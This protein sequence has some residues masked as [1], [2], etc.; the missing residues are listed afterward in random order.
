MSDLR[1]VH[2]VIG[3]VIALVT[4][5]I[6]CASNLAAAPIELLN[7]GDFEAVEGG[8]PKGWSENNAGVLSSVSDSHSG[9]LAAKWEW[10]PH[11]WGYAACQSDL[12]P[13]NPKATYRLSI[14][15]KGTGS[16]D[17]AVYQFNAALFVGTAFPKGELALTPQW[18]KL[19]V[20]YK[21]TDN[22]NI[23]FGKFAIHL[24]GENAVAILDDAS[25]RFDP[26]ENP[27]VTIEA[28]EKKR[29][30]TIDLECRDA[31]ARVFVGGKEVRLTA[32]RGRVEIAE[33]IQSIAVRAEAIGN[34][35][36]LRIRMPEHPETDGRWRV[37]NQAEPGWLEMGFDDQSWPM[38]DGDADGFAWAPD[39]SV[40][41]TFFRQL[42]LW[43][44][45]HYGPNQCIAPPAQEWG[46]SQNGMETFHHALYSPLPYPLE[47]Y[48]FVLDLPRGFRL[49]DKQGYEER[50]T[51]NDR[52]RRILTSAV[53]HEGAKYVRY[54]FSYQA[55]QLTP[56]QTHWSMI[57]V[58][59]CDTMPLGATCRFYY[60]RSAKGNFTELEQVVPVVVLPPVRGRMPKDIL[61]FS[62]YPLGSS[63]MSK[64]HLDAWMSQDTMAGLNHYVH[65]PVPPCDK[66]WQN[67]EQAFLETARR[68]NAGMIM[69]S[70]E[71]FPLNYGLMGGGRLTE[72]PAWL[73][74]DAAAHG[75]YYENR[76][77]W[78][79]GNGRDETKMPYCNQ[80]V[81]S[82]EGVE[83]WE[84]AAREV[85]R[86]LG[87]MRGAHTVFT[88]WEF[89]LLNKDGSGTHCFC[90]RCKKAF[91]EFARLPDG[92]DL[93]DRAI[94][95]HHRLQWLAFRQHQDGEIQRRL[96]EVCHKLGKQSMV[97]SWSHNMAFWE[98]CWKK[99]DV[100]F[101]GMPGFGVADSRAQ[102]GLDAYAAQFR[103]LGFS[104]GLVA[105]RFLFLPDCT[106]DGWQNVKVKSNSGYVN[107]KSWKSEILRLLAT[108]HRGVDLTEGECTLSAGTHYWIGEATRIVSEYENLFLNGERADNLAS[109]SEVRYPNLLVL[110]LGAERLVLLFNETPQPVRV[111]LHNKEVAAG[112]Q[113]TIDGVTPTAVAPEQMVVV[114]PPEDVALVHI[115]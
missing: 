67:F 38:V 94:V 97:Y 33:G 56:E 89:E 53:T 37:G 106:K 40:K 100:P 35:P 7:R 66:A 43:N 55:S 48:E 62:H 26:A 31:T 71:N 114:I 25:L 69:W 90:D 24:H 22:L 2:G 110:K 9:R 1:L 81:L 74:A 68:K 103:R 52:P 78:G 23:A 87:P 34:R 59:M 6:C 73:K 51:L 60:R 20:I 98:Q 72:Y 107:A 49:L 61:V 13:L 76:P 80:Y 54:C 82:K 32:G 112:Q 105:Q 113:A 30:L 46:F 95:S 41:T 83:F 19:D 93:S 96:Q 58:A 115:R 79:G 86:L 109:S 77:P 102:E 57:P 91:K 84:I 75:R 70:P 101:P 18:Q 108:F 104:K 11:E 10:R 14:W 12:I 8:V 85:A 5:E 29:S 99:I 27:G 111:T 39:H 36:G 28:K 92:E 45:T 65:Q 88:D 3:L 44:A 15:A 16:L 42:I 21:P 64:E 50:G 4:S 17:L 63:I 47:D